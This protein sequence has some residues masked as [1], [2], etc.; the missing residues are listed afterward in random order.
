MLLAIIAAIVA[1]VIAIVVIAIVF[2]IVSSRRSTDAGSKSRGVQQVRSVGMASSLNSVQRES[3]SRHVR[4]G[5]APA[6][7]PAAALKSRF[8][9]MGAA[10]TAV[11]GAL[12][13]KAFSMQVLNSDQYESEANANAYTTVSTPAP[14][15]L[16]CDSQGTVLVGNRSSMTVLADPDVSDDADVVGRLSTVL[17]VPRAVVRQRIQDSSTGAQSQRVVASDVRLRDV[18]F[19]AEHADAFAGVEVQTRTVR[20]YPYGALAAHVLGYTQAVTQADLDAAPEGRDLEMSDEVGREGVEAT[21]DSLLAGEHGQRVVLADAS[22]NVREVI[23]ETAPKQGSTVYLTINAQVQYVA[24]SALANLIAPGGVL[25]AGTGVAGAAVVMNVN[26]GSIVAMSSYP[27]Y[28]PS[29]FVGGISDADW[30][31]YG[32]PEESARFQDPMVNKAIGGTYPAASTYKAFTALS[33]LEHDIANYDSTWTCTGS[34]DGFGSGDWQDC[35]LH[36]GHGTLDLRGGI[37]NSCDVVFYEI[38]KSFYEQFDTLGDEAMQDT[39]RKYWFGQTLGIDIA[40][41]AAGV[42]PTPEWKAEYYRDTP[43]EATWRG[44]DQT[45]M[46]IGQGY[47]LVTPLQVACAY[48]GLATGKIPKPH[49]LKEVRNEQGEVAIS[50]TPETVTEPDVDSDYLDYVRSGLHGVATET[51]DVAPLFAEYGIDAGA[52]TGTAE[53]AGKEDSAWFACY[54]PFDDPKYVVAVLIDQGGGGSAVAAPIGAEIMNAVL[55]AS[56]GKLDVQVGTV[57]GVS[58]NVVEYVGSGSGR[59]D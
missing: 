32:D 59:T 8:V 54:A 1:V 49:L 33:A 22:G 38:A 50:F 41:E 16:I 56:E 39:I 58:G 10:A 40:G 52:K 57:A 11:F 43:E 7:N 46:V 34:W 30:A 36:S 13:A 27:P 2:R 14:R 12:L 5:N 24:D 47:V 35:W 28:E 31:I 3:A 19:I 9:F 23:S 4:T 51:N 20:D 6:A 48:A 45:N 55:Q 15:G 53:V 29:R 37:V 44:G 21:Y 25:G 26:D 18:A 42:V 17:G